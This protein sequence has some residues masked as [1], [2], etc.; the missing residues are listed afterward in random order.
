M[1]FT[2]ILFSIILC[3][4]TLL[5]RASAQTYTLIF[6]TNYG[7][8]EV[9]LYDET[10]HHRDLILAQIKKGTYKNAQFN[11]VIKDFVIQGGELDETI[12]NRERTNLVESPLRLSAEFHP[13]AFHKLGAVGAG[14]EG[15]LEKA[16][17][18]T[19]LYVVV[20]KQVTEEELNHLAIKKGIKY[21]DFQRKE[22]LK[23][24]G[25]PRLDHDYTVFGEIT[26]GLDRAIL[27]SQLPTNQ[28]DVPLKTVVFKI[29]VKKFQPAKIKKNS[30]SFG[31]G[32]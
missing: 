2:S 17:Y 28:E 1:K 4:T 32:F 20:G 25:L 22:Y 7:N 18:F 26:K 3:S 10:P 5:H 31:V 13:R 15:N 19:Q 9:M 21:T 29:K 24:G 27:I 6:K 12:L 16:S 14:H 8:F 11:R 23:K 30:I